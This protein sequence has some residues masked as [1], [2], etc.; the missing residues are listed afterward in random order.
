MTIRNFSVFCRAAALGAAVIGLAACTES[1]LPKDVRPV[2]NK[3]VNE[4]QK[5]GMSETSPIFIRV[6]KEESE[7]EVWKQRNDGKYM[8]LKTYQIC[9]WSGV[10]GPKVKEGDRQAPEG[11]YI[12]KPAQMNPNSNYY[13]SFNI[14]YP[15]EYDR[16]YGRTGSNLMVHG[17]CSSAG[18]YSMTDEAAGE[19]FALARDAFKG[20]QT[21]FQIQAFPFRMTPENI[22]RHRGDPNMDFWMN[23]KE[24]YDHFEVTRQVPT[25]N[26]C[27]KRYI[28]DADSGGKPFIAT[29]ACPPYSVPDWIS[30]AVAAKASADQAKVIAVSAKLDADA[31][32]LATQQQKVADQRAAEETKAA[33]DA[34]R[35]P[36]LKRWF[37]KNDKNATATAAATPAADVPA[38]VEASAA[39]AAPKPK[40]APKETAAAEPPPAAPKAKPAPQTASA[41]LAA[42]S[43]DEPIPGAVDMSTTTATVLSATGAATTR[44]FDW[45]DQDATMIAGGNKILPSGLDMPPPSAN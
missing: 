18:C 14:G 25:V 27:N 9:K 5:D 44:K 1:T 41:P 33:E 30:T 12:V 15:N 21:A 22:A 11:V 24:G 34:A 26:V 23:L 17:A 42:A 40:P 45:P 28:F 36:L 4:M 39:A 31:N 2:P 20:G 7:L 13:L 35:P 10:L 38:P 8:L 6:F 29:A 19:I 32:A 37:G 3:L 16:A 43:A